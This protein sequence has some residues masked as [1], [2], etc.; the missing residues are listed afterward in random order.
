MAAHHPAAAS[1]AAPATTPTVFLADRAAREEL[2]EHPHISRARAAATTR[3]PAPTRTP[4][5]RQ[6]SRS[7]SPRAERQVRTA[8]ALPADLGRAAVVVAWALARVGDAYVMDATGPV[9]FDCSGLAL[10]AYAA[11]GISLPHSSQA[12]LGYG[13][14][15]GRDEL[16]PGDLVFPNP[17]HVS[18][19]AGAGLVVEA[20]NP[21][22]GVVER[23]I[24]G[25]WM[26]V[27]LL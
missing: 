23:P 4:R 21:R 2:V 12:M 8:V 6:T 3:P 18:I 16:A 10:R 14:R 17:G 22:V 13:R 27:R 15:V 7:A 20:A 9:A 5:P 24:W 26:A 19:Y 11:V 25:F 1:A